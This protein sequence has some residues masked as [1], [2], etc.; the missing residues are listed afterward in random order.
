M[1][2]APA[3]HGRTAI[4]RCRRWAFPRRWWTAI[5]D[6]RHPLLVLFHPAQRLPPQA[7]KILRVV[8]KTWKRLIGLGHRTP[9]NCARYLLFKIA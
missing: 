5:N 6:H 8:R 3:T 1:T 9:Q 7:A 4:N 2:A